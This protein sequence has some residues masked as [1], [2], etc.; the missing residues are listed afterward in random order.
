MSERRSY[1]RLGLSGDAKVVKSASGEEVRAFLSD[2]S[3]GGFSIYSTA[4]FNDQDTVNFKFAIPSFG[5][6]LHGTGT[7]CHT[8]SP[9]ETKPVQLQRIG[10]KFSDVNKDLVQHL[11]NRLHLDMVAGK[12]SGGG[13]NVDFMPY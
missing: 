10:V 5:A 9:D 6:D 1:E 8:E 2:I 11:L 4:S 12:R 7:V 13:R 3:F